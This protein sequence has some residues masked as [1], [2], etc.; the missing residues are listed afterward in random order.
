V[1]PIS[2][3]NLTAASPRFTYSAASFDV[4]G[5]RGS[6]GDEITDRAPFNAFDSAIS[7]GQFDIVPVGATVT[8]TV[9]INPTEW[10]HTPA[11]GL[12][13]VVADNRSGRGQAQ[14]VRVH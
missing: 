7:T 6:V 13:I 3:L 10:A 12:M 14:L 9:S 8:D 11:L 4:R 2:R 5:D 1:V